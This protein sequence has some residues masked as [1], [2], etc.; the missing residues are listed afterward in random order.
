M[1]KEG[2]VKGVTVAGSPALGQ[3]RLVEQARAR[4]ESLRA[5][6]QARLAEVRDR[7]GYLQGSVI[8]GGAQIRP[9]GVLGSGQVVGVLGV[10]RPLL[11]ALGMEP[12][13]K[14]LLAPPVPVEELIK[15]EL[16]AQARAERQ[17]YEEIAER[18]SARRKAIP[19]RPHGLVDEPPAPSIDQVLVE[20][21]EPGKFRLRKF[22]ASIVP[23]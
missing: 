1:S 15:R 4:L 2:T 17:F 10:P 13:I 8:G 23:P 12:P 6:I 19:K 21:Y 16:K 3:T 14:R 20:E 5:R 7:L 9:G 22:T 18:E 11:S